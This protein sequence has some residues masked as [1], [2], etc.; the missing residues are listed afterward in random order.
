VSISGATAPTSGQALVATSSTAA[1]WQ[2]IASGGLTAPVD[3]D[4]D[5]YVAIASGGDLTYLHG[6]TS[7]NVL[8]WNS[9]G[10]WNSAPVKKSVMV[11][12]T[13]TDDTN[14]TIDWFTT[15]RGAGGDAAA[16]KK[17]G[18]NNGMQNSNACSPFIVPFDATITKAIL[19]LKGAGVQ[20]GSVTYPVIY[21]TD[22]Y[23]EGFTSESKLADIDFSISNSYTVGT[24]SVGNTNFKGSTTLSISVSEGD[25]LA[26]KFINGNGAS[27][28]GQSANAFV[29]LILEEV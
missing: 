17:S 10:F 23:L 12:Y 5:G 15:W 14:N 22:L 11:E 20:N 6:G 25:M 16:Q 7:N 28:V 21:Q 1:T 18:A 13:L 2:T 4:E 26:L 19:V 3:P 8:M 24:Y 9:G 27:V 29:V